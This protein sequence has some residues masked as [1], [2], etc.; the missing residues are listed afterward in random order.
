MLYIDGSGDFEV[1][2]VSLSANV[3]HLV[4]SSGIPLSDS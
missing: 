2:S 3:P 1:F 4:C